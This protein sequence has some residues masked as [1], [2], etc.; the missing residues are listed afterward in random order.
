MECYRKAFQLGL[1][2]HRES[3]GPGYHKKPRG[4]A[5]AAAES[6]NLSRLSEPLVDIKYCRKC[7]YS[8]RY[9]KGYHCGYMFFTGHTRTALHPEGLTPTCYEFE[10]KPPQPKK[11]KRDDANGD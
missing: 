2:K 11:Q 9:A 10:P 8:L 5:A 1:V 7:A 6:D 3:G 4:S